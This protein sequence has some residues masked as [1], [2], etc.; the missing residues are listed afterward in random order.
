[1]SVLDLEAA[2]SGGRVTELWSEWRV[3]SLGSGCFPGSEQTKPAGIGNGIGVEKAGR[4][5]S[6]EQAMS[7][8]AQERK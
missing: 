7:A 4:S 2:L 3:C 6:I 1:M 8:F 5:D